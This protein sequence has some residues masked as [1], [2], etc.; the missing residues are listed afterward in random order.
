M[1]GRH[2]CHKC[3]RGQ[4]VA[5]PKQEGQNRGGRIQGKGKNLIKKTHMRNGLCRSVGSY[6][7]WSNTTSYFCLFCLGVRERYVH[8]MRC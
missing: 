3:P 5:I 7:A 8:A 1:S 2:L 6:L 4:L